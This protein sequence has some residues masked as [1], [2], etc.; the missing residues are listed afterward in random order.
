MND[1]LSRRDALK[2]LAIGAGSLL[3]TGAAVAD[4]AK[5][6]GAA[7]PHVG[8]GD[9]VATA[10]AYVEDAK[11]V[12]PKKNPNFKPGQKCA[13][14][15]QGKGKA[16]DAWLGCNLFPNKLVNAEGWCRGYGPKAA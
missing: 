9:P 5:P 4:T 8:A 12:D 10:L 14:C 15:V 16:G 1:L 6:A 7:L 3:A 2:A 11:S 13:N